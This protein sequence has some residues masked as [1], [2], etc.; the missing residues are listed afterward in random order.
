MCEPDIIDDDLKISHYNHKQI[1]HR[2]YNVSQ[3][4]EVR[5]EIRDFGFGAN[6]EWSLLPAA[7]V[8]LVLSL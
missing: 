7:H 2:L 1:A 8:A 6:S 3:L 5:S 4:I